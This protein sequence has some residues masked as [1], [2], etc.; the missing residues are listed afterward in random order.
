M[1]DGIDAPSFLVEH[2]IVDDAPDRE[3]AVLLDRIVLEVLIAAIAVYEQPPLGI[4]L[5]KASE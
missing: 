5:A 1:F 4:A 3:L 2:P